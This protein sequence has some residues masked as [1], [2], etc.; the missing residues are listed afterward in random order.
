M[1]PQ[2]QSASQK[3]VI[4]LPSLSSEWFRSLA[5]SIT[6]VSF[7]ASSMAYCYIDFC[8][9]FLTG[10]YLLVVTDA[11]SRF[12]EVVIVHSTAAKVAISKLERL[13]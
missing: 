3:F 5:R 13:P 6:N 7:A 8:G 12:P 10:E 9:P 1:V 4:Q 2:D 11:Y